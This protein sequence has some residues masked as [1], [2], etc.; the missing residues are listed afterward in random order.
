MP[1]ID[2][3][4]ALGEELHLHCDASFALHQMQQHNIA[5][6]IARPMGSELVSH[7][8]EGNNRVLSAHSSIRALISA[9]PWLG[10][11]AIAELKRCQAKHPVGLYLHPSRQGFFP[12]ESIATPLIEFAVAANWPIVFHTGTYI[13]SDVLAVAAVARRY[14]QTPFI[15]DCAGF[16]DMWFELPSLM[17]DTSNLYLCTSLIWGRAIAN[18]VKQHG[19]SRILFGSG[20]PR[21]TVAA[22]LT[23]IRSME[24]NDSDLQAILFDNARRI[25]RCE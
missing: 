4:I 15:C 14:P 8:I 1:I 13:H 2:S 19:S 20:M 22:A 21:D 10:P 7:N 3:H 16:T 9:N 6:S 24:L 18:A 17:L 23:R 12:T 25:F 11:V 5:L